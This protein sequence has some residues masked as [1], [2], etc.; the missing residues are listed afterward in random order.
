MSCKA[1][2]QRV[3]KQYSGECNPAFK[4]GPVALKCDACG[5]EF[6][7]ERS[8]FNPDS[9]FYYCSRKCARVGQTKHY[10]AT[11]NWNEVQC[12]Q[13]GKKMLR[14]QWWKKNKRTFCDRSCFAKWKS[15]NWAGSDNPVWRGGHLDY[16]GPNW[17]RQARRARQRDNHSCQR[18]GI[19]ETQLG[20]A[21][22]V[23]HIRRFADFTL[24]SEANRLDNLVCYC[25]SCHM[26]VEW[27]GSRRG[28]DVE[29]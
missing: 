26:Y 12:E 1:E 6:Q 20:K 13:C 19:T 17:T 15:E 18:C 5:V 21:L 24:Y 28:L 22:D 29:A 16:Y 4:G 23:H 8:T 3:S 11:D 25:H 7:R 10:P 14:P 27:E 9:R 2:Y